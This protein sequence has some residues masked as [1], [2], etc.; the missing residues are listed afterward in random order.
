[1][2]VSEIIKEL[3]T[4]LGAD[5][6]INTWC[7]SHYGEDV[8]VLIGIDQK[9]PPSPQEVPFIAFS[10]AEST[11]KGLLTE[12][13]LFI[14]VLW[15]VSSEER[16]ETGNVLEYE[17]VRMCDELGSL[18]A[19]VVVRVEGNYTTASSSYNVEYSTPWFPLWCGVLSLTINLRR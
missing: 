3:A 17:G 18:I 6:A 11:D 15:G 1:M 14:D 4:K 5:T 2:K 16:I 10:S 19:D 13:A 8:N 9:R 12:P 7:Q